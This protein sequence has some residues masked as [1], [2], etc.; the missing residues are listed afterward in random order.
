MAISFKDFL[1]NCTIATTPPKNRDIWRI[2]F[3][4]VEYNVT[5]VNGRYQKVPGLPEQNWVWSPQWTINMHLPERW[6]FVQWSDQ[7]VNRSQFVPDPTWN[8]R[9]VLAQIFYGIQSYSAINGIPVASLKQISV[10]PYVFDGSRHTYPPQF[11]STNSGWVVSVQSAD[12]LHCGRIRD[13]RYI[14]ITNDALC[15]PGPIA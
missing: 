2:N 6:G 14:W 8:L 10:P 4:R 3:S 13:D 15:T 9:T 1:V 7:A 5:V 12:K 11:N